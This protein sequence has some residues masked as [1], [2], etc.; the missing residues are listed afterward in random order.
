[1]T[2]TTHSGPPVVLNRLVQPSITPDQR[3]DFRRWSEAIN[4]LDDATKADEGEAWM[5][6]AMAILEMPNK[7]ITG[8]GISSKTGGY[9]EEPNAPVSRVEPAAARRPA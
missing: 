9:A 3:R 7:E 8:N 6:S 5:A 1:M 2:G 4:Q